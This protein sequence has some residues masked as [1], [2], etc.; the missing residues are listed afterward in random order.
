VLNLR[1]EIHK[2]CEALGKSVK[3]NCCPPGTTDR[4]G[5]LRVLRVTSLGSSAGATRRSIATSKPPHRVDGRSVRSALRHGKKKTG[6]Y[7]CDRGSWR[8]AGCGLYFAAGKAFCSHA[9][10]G[11]ATAVDIQYRVRHIRGGSSDRRCAEEHIQSF[12]DRRM[13]INRV[14]H[15]GVRHLTHS[16][17][18]QTPEAVVCCSSFTLT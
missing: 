6:P 13:S 2:K 3:R 16:P 5:P 4:R 8:G 11:A 1:L 12:R 15:H 7:D 9:Q 10:L 14:A 18:A 17:S